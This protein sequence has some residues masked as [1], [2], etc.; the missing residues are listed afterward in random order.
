MSGD[1]ALAVLGD[2]LVFTRSPDLHRAGLAALGLEGRSEALRT[3]VTGLRARLG[4]LRQFGFRGANLTHPLKKAVLRYLDHISDTA[5]RARSV[6]TIGFAEDGTWGDTTDGRG[7]V[8]L[9]V[10][11]GRD[12]VTER[13]LLFGGGGAARSLAVALADAGCTRLTVAVRDPRRSGLDWAGVPQAVLVPLGTS[14]EA[15]RLT[16]DVTVAVNC[17]PLDDATGP[18]APS[19]M[20]SDVMVIDLV[21]GREISSW[22]AAARAAGMTAYDGLGLLVFQARRSIERWTGQPV[23]VEPLTRAVGWP[24]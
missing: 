4:E 11:L 20:R 1:W 18:C 8:D 22:T 23:P 5:R 24:R 9:L 3:P 12:P 15:G 17:T 2:P 6:N 21:Y 10:S 7:F 16:D 13:M 14:G 19:A